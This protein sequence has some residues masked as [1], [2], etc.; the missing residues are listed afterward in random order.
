MK[1]AVIGG[2]STYTPETAAVVEHQKAQ[3]TRAEEV[4]KIEG[5]LLARCAD[6][7][8]TALPEELMLRGGAYYSTAASQLI[9]SLHSDAGDVHIINTRHCG[10]VPGWPADYWVC[11]LPCRV[12]AASLHPLPARPLPILADGLVDAVKAY[13]LL[14]AVTGDRN[15]A[16]A[17]LVAHP[18][19]PG[20]D[21]APALW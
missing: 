9:L 4:L 12:D 2:G 5:D 20:G 8:L 1:I 11:E 19:G 7:N 15:A 14:A 6:P 21:R 10:A 17:A 13:E 16:L 3:P 18:L